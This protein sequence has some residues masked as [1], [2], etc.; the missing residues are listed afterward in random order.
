MWQ[1]LTVRVGGAELKTANASSVFQPNKHLYL[2][3]IFICITS[4]L[5]VLVCIKYTCAFGW[6]IEEVFD[7]QESTELKTLN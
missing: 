7:A 4:F 6:N 3:R 2:V 1:C 5:H